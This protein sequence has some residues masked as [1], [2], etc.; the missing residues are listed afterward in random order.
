VKKI[1]DEIN[2]TDKDFGQKVLTFDKKA[3]EVYQ[4]EYGEI[5]PKE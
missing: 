4:R 3:K 5:I 1:L 2:R